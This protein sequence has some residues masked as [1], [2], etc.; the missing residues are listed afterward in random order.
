M[1]CGT[2][3]EMGK[4][5]MRWIGLDRIGLDWIEIGG[6]RGGRGEAWKVEW[7]RECDSY[8]MYTG[9]VLPADKEL[10]NS[11]PFVFEG[12]RA[13]VPLVVFFSIL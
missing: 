7:S 12:R 3:R 13:V 2:V 6:W 8:V 10:K 1:G 5:G 9:V 4:G 11:L